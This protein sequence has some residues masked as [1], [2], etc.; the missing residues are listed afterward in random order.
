MEKKNFATSSHIQAELCT[1]HSTVS[2]HHVHGGGHWWAGDPQ[3]PGYHK[4]NCGPFF[5]TR[6][7]HLYHGTSASSHHHH[8]AGQHQYHSQRPPWASVC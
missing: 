3:Y 7:Y 1:I 6:N 8:H 2:L 4:Y 5:P